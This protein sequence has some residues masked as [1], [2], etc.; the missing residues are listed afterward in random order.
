MTGKKGHSIES[1]FCYP[2]IVHISAECKSAKSK[3]PLSQASNVVPVFQ[4]QP[5]LSSGSGYKPY[6]RLRHTPDNLQ[7][8]IY[9]VQFTMSVYDVQFT[10]CL[11]HHPSPALGCMDKSF[12]LLRRLA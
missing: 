12:P 3:M 7:F 4:A 6:S 8:T 9:N 5:S 10:M 1:C 2:I 11:P